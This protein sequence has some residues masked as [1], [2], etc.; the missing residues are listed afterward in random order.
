M[1]DNDAPLPTLREL[2]CPTGKAP[3]C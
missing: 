3:F 1:A 2:I